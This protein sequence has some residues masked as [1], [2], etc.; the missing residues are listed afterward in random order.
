MIEVSEI[1]YRWN[2]GNSKKNICRSLGIS[3]NTVKEIIKVASGLGLERGRT[4]PERIDEI[5]KLIIEARYNRPKNP[6]SVQMRESRD[7]NCWPHIIRKYQKCCTIWQN[8]P[9]IC[10]TIYN[11]SHSIFAYTKMDISSGGIVGLKSSAR[12]YPGVI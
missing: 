2:R 7:S 6:N 9:M 8:S 5:A 3:R 4:L 12:L 10:H 11:R 1:L